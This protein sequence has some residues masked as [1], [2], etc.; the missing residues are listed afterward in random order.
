MALIIAAVAVAVGSAFLIDTRRPALYEATALVRVTNPN[1]ETIFNGSPLVQVDPKR[2]VSTQIELIRSPELTTQVKAEIGSQWDQVS[3]VDVAQVGDTDIISIRITGPDP[4]IAADTA[5]RFAD[6]YVANRRGQVSGVFDSRAEELRQRADALDSQVEALSQ[7]DPSTAAGQAQI[8]GLVR[9]QQ[10]F[11]SRASQLEVEAAV[12]TGNVEIANRATAPSVAS[13]PQPRRDLPLAGCLG[14]IGALAFV[15]I[16]DRLDDRIASPDDAEGESG[17]AVLGSI[18]IFA[19]DRKRSP[20][21]LPHGVRQLVP[22]NS[23]HAEAY[24]TL[25][26]SLQFATLGQQRQT[27]MVTSSAGA[28]GK[29]TVTANLAVALAENGLRVVAIS[30]DLRRPTLAG[31]FGIT[32]SEAGLSTTLSGVTSAN[33]VMERVPVGTDRQLIVMPAGPAPPNPT[34]LMGSPAMG[35]LLDQLERAGADVILVDCPPVLPV[36]DALVLAQRVDAVLVIGVIGHTRKRSLRET[37]DRL[38]RVGAPIVGLVLNGVSFA[39]GRYGYHYYQTYGGY[40]RPYAAAD[41]SEP[42]KPPKSPKPPERAAAKAP[43][44]R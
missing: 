1:A 19:P 9:Q 20:R 5:N 43:G 18:P 4:A 10:E 42:P 2:E 33:E 28:E 7:D 15:L 24:R 25:A 14:L 12:R 40:G 3:R 38:N 8:E 26:T 30:A 37:L 35:T 29:T 36:A 34:D 13:S 22:L 16:A 17:V 39:G 6:R 11:R 32:E 44:R 23:V 41:P 31:I 27:I 21:R